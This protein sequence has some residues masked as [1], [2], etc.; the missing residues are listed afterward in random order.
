MSASPCRELMDRAATALEANADGWL[1]GC[2]A[3]AARLAAPYPEVVAT[4]LRFD[5]TFARVA[6]AATD[7]RR[8]ELVDGPKGG[9][10]A[11]LVP[12]TVEGGLAR[13]WFL[14]GVSVDDLLALDLAPGSTWFRR[15][16]GAIAMVEGRPCAGD[17]LRLHQDAH[18]FIWALARGR[19]AATGPA[20]AAR[21]LHPR[22][23]PQGVLVLDP[24][25]VDWTRKGALKGIERVELADAPVGGGLGRALRRLNR[26]IGRPGVRGGVD[27]TS[28][29]EFG[30]A[31]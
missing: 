6:P 15:A 28:E 4:V 20:S 13:G 25:A 30:V 10:P 29:C 26:R 18:R 1:W 5:W 16:L 7:P 23:L 3:L 22:P 2:R 17:V 9:R 31:A 14:P 11:V 12:L 24:A 8:F 21:P 19:S 27:L